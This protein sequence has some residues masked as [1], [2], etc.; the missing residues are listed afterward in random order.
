MRLWLHEC[1]RIFGDKMVSEADVAHF[2][3]IL[4][5]VSK[6]YFEDYDSSTLHAKPL[7]YAAFGDGEERPYKPYAQYST[8]KTAISEK[9][10]EYNEYPF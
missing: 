7:I 2:Q 1:Y 9:L 6:K 3:E 10:D 5:D 4:V 8:L